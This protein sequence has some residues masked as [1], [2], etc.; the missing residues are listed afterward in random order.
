MLTTVS[1][2]VF[3]HNLAIGVLS[4]VALNGL[5]FFCKIAQLVFVDSVIDSAREKQV[6][7]TASQIFFVS[8]NR[9]LDKFGL[10]KDIESIEIDLTHAHLWD[11]STIATLDKVVLNFRRKGVE[12]EVAGL[13]EASA[14][15]VDKL[16]MYDKVESFEDLASH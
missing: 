13:N 14:T 1:M 11:Q 7:N 8:V 9:F 15:L 3:S 6:H 5:L 4:G 12:V 16:S 10:R 2:T